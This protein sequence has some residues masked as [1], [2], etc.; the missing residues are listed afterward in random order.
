LNRYPTI[1]SLL[2]NKLPGGMS[3]SGI[4]FYY[5]PFKMAIL[6]NIMTYASVSDVLISNDAST[7]TR[8]DSSNYDQYG[9]AGSL[10]FAQL[11][12]VIGTNATKRDALDGICSGTTP[13]TL[14]T[15][16]LI[17][18]I[19]LLAETALGTYSFLSFEGVSTTTLAS[20]VYTSSEVWCLFAESLT[21]LEFNDTE[22]TS[23]VPGVAVTVGTPEVSIPN[24]IP[25]CTRYA[26]NGVNIRIH[27]IIFDQSMCNYT[28][29]Y[30]Q[31]PIVFS[32]AFATSSQVY[33]ITVI[34]S[35]V[36]V[37][38]LGGNSIVYTFQPL[39]SANGMVIYNVN[40]R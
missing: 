28:T 35:Q 1:G 20:V 15:I 25:V 4:S 13:I 8:L 6:S 27:G 23:A 9:P 29:V 18:E 30:S 36:A 11:A 17:Y 32:G 7:F 38:V 16:G 31:T 33:N 14:E 5:V 37:L 3:W 22:I 34:D 39:I 12:S 24:Q 40:F 19:I 2:A 21:L 26:A 10:L